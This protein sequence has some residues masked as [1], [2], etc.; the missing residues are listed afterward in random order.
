MFAVLLALG[1]GDEAGGAVVFHQDQVPEH[2]ELAWYLNCVTPVNRLMRMTSW[3]VH[4]RGSVSCA[5]RR[6]PVAHSP[7]WQR[8]G[9][10][11]RKTKLTS[12]SSNWACWPTPFSKPPTF[13]CTSQ[14]HR[15]QGFASWPESITHFDRV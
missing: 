1:L 3:K 11:T 5:S 7:N 9:T 10:Q 2:A 12:L 8:F 13:F 14:S 4:L 6:L 15:Q